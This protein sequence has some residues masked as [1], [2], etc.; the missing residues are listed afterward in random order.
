MTNQKTYKLSEQAADELDDMKSTMA[1]LFPMKY[2]DGASGSITVE[3]LCWWW[4]QT[5][6]LDTD[7]LPSP[8]DFT[9]TTGRGRPSIGANDQPIAPARLREGTGLAPIVSR[10][11]L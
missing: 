6:R 11:K 7:Q 3:F 5:H 2:P 10:R 1:R 9:A 8:R 4:H